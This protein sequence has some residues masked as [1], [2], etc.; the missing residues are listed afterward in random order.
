[1]K[2]PKPNKYRHGDK[3]ESGRIFIG[4]IYDYKVEKWYEALYKATN[5]VDAQ[6]EIL[7]KS[8]LQ[9]ARDKKLPFDID[10][11]YIKS[12]AVPNC[13]ALGIRLTWGSIGEGHLSTNDSPSL[14]RIKPEWGYVR[15]NVCIISNL[16]NKIKQDVGW[17]IL[18]LVAK[19]VRKMIRQAEQ[20]VRPEQLTRIPKRTSKYRKK[21]PQL[22]SVFATWVRQ[23]G[24]DIDDYSGTVYGQDVDYCTQ[25][26][27]PDGMGYGNKQ[28]ATSRQLDLFKDTGQ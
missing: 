5:K 25:A 17:K 18:F 27:G 14:D 2:P 6:I 28:V 24:D 19:F 12:I 7:H 3:H 15:G 22:W 8:A 1:V 20:N 11:D 16:A 13:P 26:S 4:Y 23:D 9:R 10:I 21:D